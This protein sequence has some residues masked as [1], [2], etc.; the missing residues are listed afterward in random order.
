MPLPQPFHG[1]FGGHPLLVANLRNFYGLRKEKEER[2]IIK[3]IKTQS[4][5]ISV[6][7]DVTVDEGVKNIKTRSG[8]CLLSLPGYHIEGH[9]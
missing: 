2:G 6:A 7:C 9:H 5:Q 1:C 8:M 3:N 4:C